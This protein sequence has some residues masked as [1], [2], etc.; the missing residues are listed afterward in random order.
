MAYHGQVLENLYLHQDIQSLGMVLILLLVE[1]VVQ[2]KFLLI[3]Q[4]V[5]NGSVMVDIIL[6]LVLI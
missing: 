2:D 6:R 4:M 3:L 5:L 1:Q